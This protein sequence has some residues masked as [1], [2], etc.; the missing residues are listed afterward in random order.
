M[1][2]SGSGIQKAISVKAVQEVIMPDVFYCKDC[3]FFK[4]IDGTCDYPIDL[5]LLQAGNREV[6]PFYWCGMWKSK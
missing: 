5:P 1:S 4:V 6:G 3:W 2:Q